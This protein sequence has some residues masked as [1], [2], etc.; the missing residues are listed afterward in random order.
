MKQGNQLI[1]NAFT[2][3]YFSGTFF[4]F[5]LCFFLIYSLCFGV[6]FFWLR[7]YV[8]GILGPVVLG[9]LGFLGLEFFL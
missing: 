5:Y 2:L 6:L 1:K 4:L 7:S 8:D 3:Y 9:L